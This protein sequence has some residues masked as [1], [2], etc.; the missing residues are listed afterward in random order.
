MH[1]IFDGFIDLIQK[2]WGV[3]IAIAWGVWEWKRRKGK[4]AKDRI[5]TVEHLVK[6]VE[7]LSLKYDELLESNSLLKMQM[8]EMSRELIEKQITIDRLR[9]RVDELEKERK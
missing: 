5:D 6:S 3:L 8:A 4:A 7:Q 2:A 1:D 9:A